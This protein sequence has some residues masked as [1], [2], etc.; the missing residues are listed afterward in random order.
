[1]SYYAVKRDGI[2]DVSTKEPLNIFGKYILITQDK[3]KAYDKAE[4]I[5]QKG[6]KQSKKSKP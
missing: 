1:M 5:L 6:D 2:V 3:A 4:K